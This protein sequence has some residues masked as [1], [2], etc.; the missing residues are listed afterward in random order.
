MNKNEKYYLPE[1][2]KYAGRTKQF[3]I[4]DA[5]SVTGLPILETEYAIK[6]MMEIYNCKLKVTESG[7]LIYDFG[8]HLKRR[9]AKSFGEYFNDF[10]AMFWK[11]FTIMYKFMISAFLVVYFVVFLVIVLAVIIGVMSGGKN[12]NSKGA[13]NMIY[14]LFRIFWS[15][16]EWN[17]IMG[18]NRTYRTKDSYGYTY[19]H[20]T[21]KEGILAGMS[22]KEGNS[23]DKKGF[24]ASVYDFVFGPPRV[25]I[26]PLA[27]MQELATYLR[28]NKGLVSTYEIQSLAGWTRA[29]AQSFMTQAL[30][31]YNGKAEI[32][33]NAVLYGDFTELIRR[34]DNIEGA[35]VIF[36]WDEFEPDYE[37]TG[38]KTERDLGIFAMNAFNLILSSIVLWGPL[39]G[40]SQG[41]IA[42]AIFLGWVP[43][44]YSLVFF[45][46]PAVR[47]LAII[48]QKRKQHLMNVRKRLMMA[49]YQESTGQLTLNQLT[50]IANKQHPKEEKLN[51]KLVEKVMMD[52]IYDLEGESFVNNN[53]EVVYKFERL[54][55]E[56]D[57]MDKIRAEKKDDSEL[58]KIVFEA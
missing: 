41:S 51:P 20:Y 11:A 55:Q 15:I 56:L 21:E 48:P 8:P 45:I 3:T 42:A 14:V 26:H 30:G 25:E 7:N 31:N 54:D 57:D 29:E 53:A 12:D 22:G 19:K 44:I 2:E 18:Y 43:L 49:I 39:S 36:Y 35:P 33:D 13:G 32:S 27:N 10:L 9:D 6:D 58:G 34:K 37:L 24:V 52:V 16:F 47:Y 38:N 23:K 50:E 28:Q 5:A 17:T 4:N 46:I 1:L 40:L